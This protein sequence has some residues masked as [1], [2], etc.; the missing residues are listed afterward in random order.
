MS[1]LFKNIVLFACCLLL[2]SAVV[3][4]LF[5]LKT[6]VR[7]KDI[8]PP[9]FSNSIAF[10]DKLLFIQNKK[11]DVVSI[12]SSMTANNM[13]SE[14]IVKQFN[15]ESY[16]NTASWGVCMKDIF[17]LF[18]SYSQFHKP[19][20]CIMSSNLID[21]E[22]KKIAIDNEQLYNFISS[23]KSENCFFY[24]KKI[25]VS[26]YANYSITLKEYKHNKTIYEYLGYDK[27]GAV[28][29]DSA[30]FQITKERWNQPTFTAPQE[31]QYAYLDSLSTF[32]KN[33]DIK[34]YFFESPFRAGLYESEHLD[35]HTIQK[36]VNRVR[37]LLEA[38]G[39]FFVD[40]NIKIWKD[41]LFLDAIHFHKRGAQMYTQYCFDNLNTRDTK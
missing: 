16:L 28:L 15:T 20:V 34:F 11:A 13:D 6:G 3:T 12:G 1:N 14:T 30:N 38:R 5:F 21:F 17:L 36:H 4:R 33:N 26:Y 19:K 7:L 8:P 31:P 18:K 37:A 22:D 23:D 25:N 39:Q 10:N 9:N 35:T 41:S 32:C 2:F 24:F 29:L 40:S 27:Y